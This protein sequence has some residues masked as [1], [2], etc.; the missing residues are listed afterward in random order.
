MLI[1]LFG[2]AGAKKILERACIP[3][4]I[5]NRTQGDKQEDFQNE[6]NTFRETIG[7]SSLNKER[8]TMNMYTLSF[9]CKEINKSTDAFKQIVSAVYSE[10]SKHQ[11]A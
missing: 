9:E 1:N 5:Q 11:N 10:A 6:C 2:A 4:W 7:A 8:E 3:N